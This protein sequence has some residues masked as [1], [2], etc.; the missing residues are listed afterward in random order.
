MFF[1]HP[2]SVGMTAR[3]SHAFA[4]INCDKELDLCC[5]K[6]TG[7]IPLFQAFHS[8]QIYPLHQWFQRVRLLRHA[9]LGPAICMLTRKLKTISLTNTTAATNPRSTLNP[10]KTDDTNP[11]NVSHYN[12]MDMTNPTCTSHQNKIDATNLTSASHNSKINVPNPTI[13]SHLYKMDVFQRVAKLYFLLL[14]KGGQHITN[15][16]LSLLKCNTPV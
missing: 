2:Q 12:T 16:H 13:N 7:S 14:K 9:Q 6:G 8:G 1:S 10:Y 15:Q 5:M 4:A 3:P 11:T